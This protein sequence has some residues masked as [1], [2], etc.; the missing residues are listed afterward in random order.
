MTRSA[1]PLLSLVTAL[2][3]LGGSSA[4]AVETTIVIDNFVFTPAERT[5]QA[6][7]TVRFVNHDDIPHTVILANGKTRSKALDTDESFVYVFDKPGDFIYFCGL[8]PQMKGEIKVT[9]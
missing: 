2:V 8:H 9:P 6:G 5:V 4:S 7:T 1:F 3:V